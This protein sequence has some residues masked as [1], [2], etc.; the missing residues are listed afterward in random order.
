MLDG[1]MAGA[2]LTRVMRNSMFVATVIFFG[3]Y[4]ALLPVLGN[5]ALWF[6]F[7]LYI[8]LRLVLQYFMSHRLDD[9][10]KQI[11]D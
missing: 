5:D 9:I 2:T 1:V 8:I 3:V 6:A 10:Y 4:Y 11:K 7:T